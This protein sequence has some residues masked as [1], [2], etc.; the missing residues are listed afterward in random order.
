MFSWRWLFDVLGLVGRLLSSCFRLCICGRL[1]LFSWSRSGRFWCLLLG[2]FRRGSRWLLQGLVRGRIGLSSGIRSVLMG[3]GCQAI[4]FCSYSFGKTLLTHSLISLSCFCFT[5][6][7]GVSGLP[8][9][10]LMFWR[11]LLSPAH[12]R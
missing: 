5:W 7:H 11:V 4:G 2:V 6:L 8:I 1:L 12:A 3:W 9:I 10:W